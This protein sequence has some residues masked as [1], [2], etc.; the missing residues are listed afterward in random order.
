MP[1]RGLVESSPE[2]DKTIRPTLTQDPTASKTKYTDSGLQQIANLLR[3]SERER[4]STVPRIYTVLR[5]IGQPQLI[6]DFIDEGFT[7]IWFPFTAHNL[8]PRLSPSIKAQFLTTQSVVFTQALDLEKKEGRHATFAADEPLWFESRGK[9]GRGAFGVVDK[10]VSLI[11]L[12]EYARKRMRRDNNFPKSKR[13]IKDFK[14]ELAILKTVNH[15]HCVKLV[16]SYTD[17]VYLGL[18]MDPVAD[19]DLGRFLAEA[20][21][22]N[23]KKSLLRGYF[24]CLA[25][26]LQYLHERQIRHRDIKPPNILVKGYTVY[27]ADFGIALD[28]SEM[29]RGTTTADTAKSPIYCAPEVAKSEPRAQ[30]ADIWSLGCVFVEMVSVLKGSSVEDKRSHFKKNFW[31]LYNN[32]AFD[33]PPIGWCRKMLLFERNERYT[34]DQLLEAIRLES[35]PDHSKYFSQ[36]FCGDCCMDQE[37]V[38][39]EDNDVGEDP[40]ADSEDEVTLRT[41]NASAQE[42]ARQ[43][44]PETIK[45]GKG[46]SNSV[47]ESMPEVSSHANSVYKQSRAEG[48]RTSSG[49]SVVPPNSAMNDPEEASSLPERFAGLEIGPPLRKRRSPIPAS[50]SEQKR[51]LGKYLPVPPPDI[52]PPWLKFGFPRSR[53][54]PSPR[55]RGSS[56]KESRVIP[57]PSGKKE[58][59]RNPNEATE[60][61]VDGDAVVDTTCDEDSGSERMD[62]TRVTRHNHDS[63][64]STGA[65]VPRR[66]AAFARETVSQSKNNA[67]TSDA[68]R[69]RRKKKEQNSNFSID[70]D[71]NATKEQTVENT[72][73]MTNSERP[74]PSSISSSR[75]ESYPSPNLGSEYPLAPNFL[76]NY[77]RYSPELDDFPEDEQSYYQQKTINKE[78]SARNYP[79]APTAPKSNSAAETNLGAIFADE[80]FDLE[81]RR[82]PPGY[83]RRQDSL[84]RPY[85]LDTSTNVGNQWQSLVG[86]SREQ[87]LVFYSHDPALLAFATPDAT[88]NRDHH[89]EPPK[90]FQSLCK[91]TGG[92]ASLKDE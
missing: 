67:P 20:S 44:I 27:L 52:S 9:L 16:G 53:K 41:Q 70:Y 69:G 28:W 37:Y 14:A 24:G 1:T 36:S 5:S 60:V 2:D 40:W 71:V 85:Y 15:H 48:A 58:E 66:A 47:L 77:Q 31:E 17:P 76:G 89:V 83:V 74:S 43:Q 23:D 42:A 56:R 64:R 90:G 10:V 80:C 7:D 78:P 18:I 34:A 39:S 8:P 30:S 38:W 91:L 22:N 32:S 45:S 68:S 35:E 86:E 13:E 55:P 6:D 75:Q 12:H 51:L 88:L 21:T 46:E 63:D 54:E 26:A 29:T 82:L 50:P 3:L 25:S 11:T 84:G 4:W 92:V 61:G 72:R 33:N 87:K 57:K 65:G 49:P 73:K 19:C 81:G 59:I 79:P 62:A